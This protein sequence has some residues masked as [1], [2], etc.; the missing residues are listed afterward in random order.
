MKNDK[1][2]V[3][4]KDFNVAIKRANF[5]RISDFSKASGVSYWYCRMIMT[6]KDVD[7]TGDQIIAVLEAIQKGY[8]GIQT[9]PMTYDNALRHFKYVPQSKEIN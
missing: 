5:R 3:N 9:K 4:A 6:D 7:L 8:N 2:R 1:I